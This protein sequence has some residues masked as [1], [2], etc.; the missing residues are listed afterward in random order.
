MK[1]DL[2]LALLAGAALLTGGCNIWYN[3]VPSPDDLMHRVPWFDHML[4]SKAVYPYQ[5]ADVPRETPAGTVPIG[6]AEADWRRFS[7]RDLV[8]SFDVDVANTVTR[9]ASLPAVAPGRGE[10]LYGI[11][12]S[13]CHG[14][15]G[16]GGGTVKQIPAPA[17]NTER[18]IGHS[19]GYL[20]SVVRYGWGLMPQYGDKIVRQE[21]R[22]AVVD[23]VRSLQRQQPQAGGTQ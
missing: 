5:T 8:Y 9:P 20:Y 1:R 15:T 18:A 22:W 21:D 19:D 10:E 12:C 23:Y 4:G 17:L 13:M 14:P 6:G 2:R 16:T 3:E 7:P 11:Y